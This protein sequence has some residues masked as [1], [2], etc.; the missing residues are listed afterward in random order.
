MGLNQQWLC[1]YNIFDC[2]NGVTLEVALAACTSA[3][4]LA[5]LQK[6]LFALAKY[7]K[8]RGSPSAL[9]ASSC[10]IESDVCRPVDILPCSAFLDTFE[11]A[12]QATK[13]S[14]SIR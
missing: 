8:G 7:N 5:R 9:A 6:R 3:R 11:S 1:L 2:N 10:I 14:D 13:R 4:R 12:S